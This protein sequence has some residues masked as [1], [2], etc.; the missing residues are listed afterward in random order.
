M[1]A[2]SRKG[3]RALIGHSW[4][5]V[6][7]NVEVITQEGVMEWRA[8]LHLPHV[9]FTFKDFLC[10]RMLAGWRARAILA[11]GCALRSN[12]AD[13]VWF[14]ADRIRLMLKFPRKTAAKFFVDKVFGDTISCV[15]G[16]LPVSLAKITVNF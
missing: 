11:G 10:P 14:G 8:R 12:R 9:P 1:L 6:D 13:R 15:Q 5:R 2:A 4:R 16:L 7:G 3:R